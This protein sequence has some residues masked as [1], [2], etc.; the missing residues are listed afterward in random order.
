MFNDDITVNQTAGLVFKAHGSKASRR[1]QPETE[2]NSVSPGNLRYYFQSFLYSDDKIPI[3]NA[4][5]DNSDDYDK[6]SPFNR[7]I[8][9]EEINISISKLK[10][11]KSHV[12]MEGVYSDE[13]SVQ[14]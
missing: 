10:T 12:L 7:P 9:D 4:R 5:F 13:I 2:S 11:G 14:Y 8:R 3:N 1:T 6:N